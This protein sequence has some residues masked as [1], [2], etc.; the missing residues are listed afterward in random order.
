MFPSSQMTNWTKYT[1]SDRCLQENDQTSPTDIK[2][3]AEVTQ[4][5]QHMRNAIFLDI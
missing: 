1:D 3:I 4:A 2:T 5:I